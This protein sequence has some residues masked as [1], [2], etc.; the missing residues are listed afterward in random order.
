LRVEACFIVEDPPGD[1]PAMVRLTRPLRPE[2]VYRG[3][4][5]TLIDAMHATPGHILTHRQLQ[6]VAAAAGI[7]PPSVSQYLAY[8]EVFVHHGADSWTLVGNH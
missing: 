6:R 7:G 3:A 4:V 1:T 5:T 8:H 2:Q